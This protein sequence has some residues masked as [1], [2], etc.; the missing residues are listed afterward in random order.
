LQRSNLNSKRFTCGILSVKILYEYKLRIVL[1]ESILTR[2]T[3]YYPLEKVLLLYAAWM[4]MIQAGGMVDFSSDV[5]VMAV[6]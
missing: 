4:D 3:E 1:Q 2:L 6:N 5:K